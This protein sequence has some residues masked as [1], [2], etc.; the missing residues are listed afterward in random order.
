VTVTVT[1]AT[2]AGLVLSVVIGL[3]ADAR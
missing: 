2:T 1:L 3:L